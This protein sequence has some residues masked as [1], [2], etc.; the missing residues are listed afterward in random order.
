[1]TPEERIF[2][3]ERFDNLHEEIHEVALDVAEIKQWKKDQDEFDDSIE[4][5][6]LSNRELIFGVL[7][8]LGVIA[9]II[10]AF[11]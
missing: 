6:S 5:K 11:I 4:S 9:G 2:I 7:G 1:M 3:A 8:S 10:V